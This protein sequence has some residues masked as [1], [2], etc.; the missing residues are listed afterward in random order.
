M[1]AKWLDT[2]PD[3]LILDEPTAGIDIGSKAEIIALVR[4]LAE[5]KAVIVISSELAELLAAC[6]RIVVMSTGASSATSP[7]RLRRPDRGPTTK[8]SH[9]NSPSANS[10][11]HHAE[12]PR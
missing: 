7:R 11:I 12:E 6:D 1:I 5:G 3:V 9:S 2:E 4:D 8:A 10:P